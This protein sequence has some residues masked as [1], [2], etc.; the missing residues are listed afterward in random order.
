VTGT[1]AARRALL[2]ALF[3]GLAVVYCGA[4]FPLD[5]RVVGGPGDFVANSAL[6]WIVAR[7]LVERG[8][9][10]LWNP[11]HYTGHP[12]IGTPY[13]S[14]FNP[15]AV[16]PL[17]LFGPVNGAKVATVTAVALAGL[18]QYWLSRVLGHGRVV[19]L[20]AGALGLSAGA[21][22]GRVASGM[23]Y[24]QGMQHAWMAAT[25]AGYLVALRTRRPG[26]IA[27]AALCYALLFHAGNLYY[28][29]GLTAVLALFT[30]GY[31]VAWDGAGAA[32][33]LRLDPR[34][35]RAGVA[36]AGVA[37]L[38]VAVQALPAVDLRG[39]VEKPVD[40]TIQSAQPPLVTLFDFVVADQRF[41]AQGQFGASELGWGVH[42]AYL[43]AG[44][45]LFLLFLVPA[46]R[47]RPSR[48]LPLLLL[49][50]ALTVAV[51][52]AKH[53]F[54]LDL[55]QRSSLL[56]QFRFW[57]EMTAVTTVVLIPLALAG[58]DW[59]WR[60]LAAAQQGLDRWGPRLAW[61]RRPA[62]GQAAG[63]P[64]AAGAP[65][66]SVGLLR[67]VLWGAL[68]LLLGRVAADPWT[69]NRPLWHTPP[70]RQDTDDLLAWLR[71]Y[72]REAFF[73]ENVDN[74]VAN[75]AD[76]P[77]IRYDLQILNSSWVLTP[78]LSAPPDAAL[79]GRFVPA[80][81]YVLSH[82]G[83][84]PRPGT[85]PLYS[86]PGG[87]IATGPP[88]L[89]FAF[90]AD[91]QRLPYGPEAAASALS[92]GT[93][94]AAVAR[95]DGP[96]RIVVDVPAEVPPTLTTLVVFQTAVPGWRARGPDGSAAPAGTAGGFLARTG[97]R[98]GERYVFSFRPPSFVAGATL[99]LLG[100]VVVTV[101][102]WLEFAPS[103]RAGACIP[104]AQGGGPTAAGEWAARA[105]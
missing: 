1:C 37:F 88:G 86:A 12:L 35:V 32:R 103:R 10:P 104:P 83:D 43:G 54:V 62:P 91:P 90:A 82:R 95:F 18:G 7:T 2:L 56:R 24:E 26:A 33:P 70:Y 59:L 45:F 81:K 58:A 80:P 96:N 34:P 99:S 19:A 15:F 30:A 11:Y 63:G 100:L 84:A 4:Y 89:P 79:S 17:L 93:V 28:W 23:S 76:V 74:V 27:V 94:A 53:T 69:T 102:L 14:F 65:W 85:T 55:W 67:P 40:A 78:K 6:G 50:T 105:P 29:L 38:L 13:I 72:D 101:L 48:D 3:G 87:A 44:L 16:G 20:V 77:L 66:P 21:L 61:V 42:Y 97:V 41:W 75:Y 46:F 49:A 52:S 39:R 31:G 8:E 9:L 36:V 51:A 25:L 22:T 73:I 68:L 47:A 60:R 64:G 57:G 98:A 92:Q 71:R 5:D